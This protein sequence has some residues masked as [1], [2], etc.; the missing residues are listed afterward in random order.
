M[1]KEKVVQFYHNHKFKT[2]AK[3][4]RLEH[5]KL[6][7]LVV[8]HEKD[9]ARNATYKSRT[10]CE[11]PPDNTATATNTCLYS[12]YGCK[13]K[14]GHMTAWSKH[15]TFHISKCGGL[16]LQDAVSKWIEQ[17]GSVPGMYLEYFLASKFDKH[18]LNLCYYLI[19]C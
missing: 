14:Q 12:K 16:S 5:K 7:E 17:N 2:K 4:K 18:Y 1:D 8:A 19:S 11:D 9:V 10:G 15:C 3:R 13:G 6:K